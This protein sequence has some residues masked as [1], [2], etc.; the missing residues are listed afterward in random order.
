MVSVRLASYSSC[1]S[2]FGVPKLLKLAQSRGGVAVDSR[3]LPG[4]WQERALHNPFCASRT[5]LL[6]SSATL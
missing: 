3:V 2:S 1:V 4:F 5:A 6:P